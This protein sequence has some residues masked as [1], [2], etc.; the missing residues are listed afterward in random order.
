[1][2]VW[3]FYFI[4]KHSWFIVLSMSHFSPGN[5]ESPAISHANERLTERR[6]RPRCRCGTR[7]QCSRSSEGDR[8]VRAV[9]LLVQQTNSTLP[10]ETFSG[11][12]RRA[13]I[14]QRHIIYTVHPT[15]CQGAGLYYVTPVAK[16]KPT[17]VSLATPHTPC[18]C[19]ITSEM[20]GIL[21]LA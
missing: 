3:I 17:L 15:N 12:P 8:A 4:S 2:L 18:T 20:Q 13:Y 10:P 11:S 16:S 5:G 9:Q 1:M 21:G 14:V 19:I 6:P 7:S